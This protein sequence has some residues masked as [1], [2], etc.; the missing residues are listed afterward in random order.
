[1]LHSPLRRVSFF[2]CA[3]CFGTFGLLSLTRREQLSV[4]LN[5]FAINF[6]NLVAAKR[7]ERA[8]IR[9]KILSVEIPLTH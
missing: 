3:L 7:M 5:N 1:M 8:R 4:N 9:K 2:F 6:N